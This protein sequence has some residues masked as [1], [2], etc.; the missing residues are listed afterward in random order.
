M[1]D[2]TKYKTKFDTHTY[3]QLSLAKKL[4]VMAPWPHVFTVSV[5]NIFEG[6]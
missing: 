4:K 1:C 6:V 2:F 5:E 3:T